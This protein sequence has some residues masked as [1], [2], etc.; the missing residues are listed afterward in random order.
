MASVI[1]SI[2]TKIDEIGNRFQECEGGRRN[3][4][5]EESLI[6]LGIKES[7]GYGWNDTYTFTK[8][9][10]EQLLIQGLGKENLTILRPSIIESTLSSPVPGWV[11]GVKVADALILSLIHI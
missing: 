9:L 11:E 2:Q 6:Q 3:R 8:W 1:S 10:G 4:N 5:Y 7:R